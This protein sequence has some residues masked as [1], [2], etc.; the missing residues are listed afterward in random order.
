MQ[1]GV[2]PRRSGAKRN[3]SLDQGAPPIS[4]NVIGLRVPHAGDAAEA[5]EVCVA[6]VLLASG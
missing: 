3:S 6:D 5:A 4:R 2:A 1:R